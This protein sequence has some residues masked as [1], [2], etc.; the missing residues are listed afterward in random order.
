[1]KK[2]F[3]STQSF[4]FV[5]HIK[6]KLE[7]NQFEFRFDKDN[8]EALLNRLKKFYIRRQEEKRN[9]EESREKTKKVIDKLVDLKFDI[10][11]LASKYDTNNKYEKLKKRIE[12]IEYIKFD[13]LSI[14]DILDYLFLIDKFKKFSKNNDLKNEEFDLKIQNF[15]TK[16]VYLLCKKSVEDLRKLNNR[17][18]YFISSQKNGTVY[19]SSLII[20]SIEDLLRRKHDFEKVYDSYLKF[21]TKKELFDSEQFQQLLESL[22]EKI[23]SILMMNPQYKK[24]MKKH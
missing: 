23:K 24:S 5:K 6:L 4:E 11:D 3:L 20:V 16:L 19:D 10:K 17:V 13:S 21:I 14:G 22:N 2:N 12:K 1:M 18:D 8:N 9:I 7:Y 15:E